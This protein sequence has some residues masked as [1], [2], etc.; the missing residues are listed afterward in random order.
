MRNA[1]TAAGDPAVPGRLAALGRFCFRH[2]R[3]VLGLWAVVL[4]VGVLIG[5]RVFEGTVAGASSATAEADRGS[6]V[7]A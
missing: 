3:W 7:V 4:V 2:R 5:G 1:P 6:A